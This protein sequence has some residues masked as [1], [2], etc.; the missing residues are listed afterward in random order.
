[1]Q[2]VI[3]AKPRQAEPGF[4]G[5][6]LTPERVHSGC[7]VMATRAYWSGRIRL[8]LVSIP[9]HL[10]PATRSTAKISFNQVHKPSG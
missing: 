4:A 1:M 9:V 10:F 3:G 6:R 2:G 8:A 7:N 5:P